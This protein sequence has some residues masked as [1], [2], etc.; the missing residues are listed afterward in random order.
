MGLRGAVFGMATP[1]ACAARVTS[2]LANLLLAAPPAAGKMP[3][4]KRATRK[5]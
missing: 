4:Q 3:E 1:E 2:V 5:R